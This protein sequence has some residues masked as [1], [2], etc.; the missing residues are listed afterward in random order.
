[1]G[2]QPLDKPKRRGRNAL[3]RIA[4][5]FTVNLK[6]LQPAELFVII[7]I[8]FGIFA[9]IVTPFM[10][11]PDEIQHFERSYQVSQLQFLAPKE[12]RSPE[13]YGGQLPQSLIDV[14]HTPTRTFTR[15]TVDDLRHMPLNPKLR[16]V[17]VFN[18]TAINSP[19]AYIPQ[20]I[21][22]DVGRLLNLGPVYLAYMGCLSNLFFWIL[23]MY[24]AIKIIPFGKWAL[25]MI[26]LNPIS[27]FLAATLSS[28]ASQISLIALLVAVV[29]RLRTHSNQLTPKLLAA[30][31]LLLIAVSLL[32][33]A[34][35][36]LSLLIMLVPNRVI[37]LPKK[38]VMGGAALIIGLAWLVAITPIA[39]NVPQFFYLPRTIDPVSQTNYIKH[40]VF[41]YIK[42]LL[43]NVWH[44]PRYADFQNYSQIDN[45]KVG[46]LAQVL[47]S[48]ALLVAIIYR[49]E[50]RKLLAT[51]SPFVR[52]VC[53]FMVVICMILLFTALYEGYSPV[54]SKIIYGLRGRYYI[55]LTIL[56]MPIFSLRFKYTKKRH[57]WFVGALICT[58]ILVLIISFW[59]LKTQYG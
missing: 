39:N 29:L 23:I 30:F 31:L 37:S 20:A 48:G 47:Y 49:D 12:T 2:S 33:I 54:G 46:V 6:A 25:F 57:T 13:L 50:S 19:V 59:A 21:G 52:I 41:G 14:S 8:V 4:Y 56:L 28:D 42:T 51:I 36:P 11:A 34:Y 40:H 9:I 7:A 5:N 35:I 45:V 16:S 1:M 10:S 44:A 38:L 15:K 22:I 18:N 27:I 58:S 3:V 17:T 55:P 32:K 43:Y 24:C 53:T 26:A